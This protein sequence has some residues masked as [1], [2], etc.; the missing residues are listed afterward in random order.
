MPAYL[1]ATR[2]LEASER[3]LRVLQALAEPGSCM[4][5]LALRLLGL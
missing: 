4:H 2:R 1:P 3:L 5:R